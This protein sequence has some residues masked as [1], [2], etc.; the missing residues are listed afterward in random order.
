VADDFIR[1][2]SQRSIFMGRIFISR[3]PV[4]PVLLVIFLLP[5]CYPGGPKDFGD[6]GVVV[7][8]YDQDADFDGLSTYAMVDEL[9]DLSNPDNESAEPIS[10]QDALIILDEINS[11]M[12][13]AGFILE[14]DPENNLPDVY[15]FAGATRYDSYVAF[16]QWYGYPGYWGGGGWGYP[17]YYPGTGYVKFEEGTIIL[18][19]VDLR[20]VVDD[21]DAGD[22]DSLWYGAV[23][24]ALTGEG[25]DPEA[26]IRKGI[27]QC[28]KQSS[29]IQGSGGGK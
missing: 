27:D 12:V 6:I 8:W 28:F 9:E 23:N 17:G 26:D 3:L 20:D 25:T 22:V 13:E 24:G 29:Y 15:V 11:Q 7:T 14:T 4:L 10:P 16:Q 18:E 21:P 2:G 19:M 1:K 5:A